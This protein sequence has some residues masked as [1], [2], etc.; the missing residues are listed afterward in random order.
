MFFG[1]GLPC[2][3]GAP[4]KLYAIANTPTNLPIYMRMARWLEVSWSW[5][6]KHANATW[7]SSCCAIYC[8]F[9]ITV[10]ILTAFAISAACH[11]FM[12][13]TY[14]IKKI[15]DTNFTAELTMTVENFA[16]CL[17]SCRRQSDPCDLSLFKVVIYFIFNGHQ[18]LLQ[19]GLYRKSSQAHT[20]HNF[21]LIL[22]RATSHCQLHTYM[23]TWKPAHMPSALYHI[24][25]QLFPLLFTGTFHK[26]W[27]GQ[28]NAVGW[29]LFNHNSVFSRMD[30][31]Q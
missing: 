31:L 22:Q 20:Q 23:I 13:A 14:A 2:R 3:P 18:S 6:G 12:E 15:F 10:E 17:A 19:W 4:K 9:P 1:L 8:N 25:W 16:L 21:S 5:T 30:A 27:Q 24:L 26:A 29:T 28:P 7:L 11:V